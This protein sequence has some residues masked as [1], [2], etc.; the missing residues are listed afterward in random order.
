ME[1]KALAD[2]DADTSNAV[3]IQKSIQVSDAKILV[4]QKCLLIQVLDSHSCRNLY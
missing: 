1:N 2:T 4:L 3:L